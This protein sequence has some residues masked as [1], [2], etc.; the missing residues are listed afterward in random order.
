MTAQ[1]GAVPK[2]GKRVAV[3]VG[4]G[5][6]SGLFAG[7]D[8]QL[9]ERSRRPDPDAHRVRLARPPSAIGRQGPVERGL[10]VAVSTS[11][12]GGLRPR[13][14]SDSCQLR[15]R[16]GLGDPS[17][18]ELQPP[19]D[20]PADLDGRTAR[21]QALPFRGPRIDADGKI[22]SGAPAR[23]AARHHGARSR[24]GAFRA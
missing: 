24:H 15:W 16:A 11:G 21:A 22:L 18:G 5:R 20:R 19:S 8:A 2:V 3:A 1:S 9:D 17:S 6:A 14:P 4:R 23:I 13:R 10:C 12:R 7:S